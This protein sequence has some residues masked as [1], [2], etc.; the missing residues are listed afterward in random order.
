MDF[1]EGQVNSRLCTICVIRWWSHDMMIAMS[2]S[3]VH[4]W[5][6]QQLEMK[7][8]CIHRLNIYT[9][10]SPPRAPSS[11]LVISSVS[12]CSLV[13]FKQCLAPRPLSQ[14]NLW[15][16]KKN[17]VRLIVGVFC[18]LTEVK[19]EAQRLYITARETAVVSQV[20]SDCLIVPVQEVF[21]ETNQTNLAL[22]L[23]DTFLI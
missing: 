23:R 6:T 11:C 10:Y 13:R 21:F 22:C 14:C 9:A 8:V 17:S 19:Q 5:W 2:V 15:N 18:F 4:H 20:Y 16:K 7:S 3:L 1:T 12:N